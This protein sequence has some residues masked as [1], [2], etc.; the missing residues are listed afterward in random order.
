[1]YDLTKREL[2][3]L[4]LVSKGLTSKEIGEIL[5][6]CETTVISHRKNIIKKCRACNT[7]ELI[8]IAYQNHLIKN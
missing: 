4:N 1:M 3:V 8:R 7:A 2:E 6:I 5:F